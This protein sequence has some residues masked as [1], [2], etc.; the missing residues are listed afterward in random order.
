[1]DGCGFVKRL[2]RQPG[3]VIVQSDNP[4]YKSFDCALDGESL[5]VIGRVH[6]VVKWID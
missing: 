4:T 1:M 2:S 6:C 3:K 5:E